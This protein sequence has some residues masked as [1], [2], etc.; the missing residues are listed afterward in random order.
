MYNRYW[1]V[2]GIKCGFEMELFLY[3]KEAELQGY[4]DSELKNVFD[5]YWYRGATDTEVAH[6]KAL[7]LHVYMI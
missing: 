4:V 7:H 5:Y 6:A 1:V 2:R 3:G